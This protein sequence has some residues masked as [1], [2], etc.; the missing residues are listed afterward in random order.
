MANWCLFVVLGTFGMHLKQFTKNVNERL[1][2]LLE[3]EAAGLTFLKLLVNPIIDEDLPNSWP[4]KWVWNPKFLQQPYSADINSYLNIIP[5]P[6]AFFNHRK[7]FE[8]IPEAENF[9]VEQQPDSRGQ[10]RLS[11]GRAQLQK[12]ILVISHQCG[13]TDYEFRTVNLALGHV[14]KSIVWPSD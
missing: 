8:F 10:F 6:E 4:G 9:V 2:T 3:A 7:V 1:M 5:S 13:V 12:P 11:S 14:L